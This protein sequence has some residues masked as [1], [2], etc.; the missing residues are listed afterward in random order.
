MSGWYALEVVVVDARTG[1]P[2]VEGTIVTA[3]DSTFLET[4]R[5]V[6]SRDRPPRSIFG[7]AVER[8]GTYEVTVRR[9]GYRDWSTTGV[10]VTRDG[11]NL[12]TRRLEARLERVP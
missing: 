4:L 12:H 1:A 9:S 5:I 3:R 6:E 11:C 2:R 7:G 10:Q 8:P